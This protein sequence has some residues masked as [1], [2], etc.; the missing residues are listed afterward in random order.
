[1]AKMLLAKSGFWQLEVC[2]RRHYKSTHCEYSHQRP[3]CIHHLLLPPLFS[4]QQEFVK[5]VLH[6]KPCK[7]MMMKACCPQEMSTTAGKGKLAPVRQKTV[8]SVWSSTNCVWDP[9]MKTSSRHTEIHTCRFGIINMQ[10][11]SEI[12]CASIDLVT[13]L[14]LNSQVQSSPGVSTKEERNSI[15]SNCLHSVT[16]RKILYGLSSFSPCFPN[17]SPSSSK[18]NLPWEWKGKK[19]HLPSGFKIIN[20]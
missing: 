7:R 3:G 14:T 18:K 12:S 15:S 9:Q 1:M 5:C 19:I 13:N 6:S 16:R 10:V 11:I 20:K 8:S 2:Y 17:I 4:N